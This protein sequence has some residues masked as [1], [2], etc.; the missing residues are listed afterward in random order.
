MRVL[1]FAKK[2]DMLGEKSKIPNNM[3]IPIAI[4]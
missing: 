1:K 3:G 4:I 2:I